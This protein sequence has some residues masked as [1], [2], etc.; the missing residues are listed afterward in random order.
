M[1]ERGSYVPNVEP[2][3]FFKNSNFVTQT[4]LAVENFD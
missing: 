3:Q 4:Y 1:K 2:L